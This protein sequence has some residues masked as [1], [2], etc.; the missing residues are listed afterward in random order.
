M[1]PKLL[2]VDDQ[3]A[4]GTYI[5][6]V[7]EPLGYAVTVTTDS[8][9]AVALVRELQPVSIV[10]DIVMPQMDG[11]EILRALGA[12]HCTA[13]ILIVTGFSIEYLRNASQLSEPF[14]LQRVTTMLKPFRLAALRQYL[15]K[16]LP[17]A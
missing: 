5:Q 10:L 6:E 3:A 7:A 15:T 11:L 2:V 17:V 14:G 13:N 12:L 1:Q 9:R 16:T 8:T 4:I